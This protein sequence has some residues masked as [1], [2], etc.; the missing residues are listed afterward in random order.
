MVV[1]FTIPSLSVVQTFFLVNGSFWNVLYL[2]HCH[3]FVSL[4][5]NNIQ[6]FNEFIVLLV[7]YH[8]MILL[9]WAN[10]MEPITYERIGLSIIYLIV[11]LITVNMVFQIFDLLQGL[12]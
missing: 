9:Q 3:P 6:R 4:R 7:V 8:V 12:H 2:I 5:E 11:I 1:P 10:Q